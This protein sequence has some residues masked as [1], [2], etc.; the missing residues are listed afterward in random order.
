[1]PNIAMQTNSCDRCVTVNT[2]EHAPIA[3]VA[4]FVVRQTVCLSGFLFTI[5][6]N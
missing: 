3:T 1:M 5:F 2:S 4:N 6:L